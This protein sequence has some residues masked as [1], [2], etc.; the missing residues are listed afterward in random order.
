MLNEIGEYEQ[1]TLSPQQIDDSRN[2]RLKYM[3][4]IKR[5]FSGLERALTT[6]ARHFIFDTPVGSDE[7]ELREILKAWCGFASKAK[8]TLPEHFKGWLDKY[9]CRAF[10]NPNVN[11][12]LEEISWSEETKFFSELKGIIEKISADGNFDRREVLKALEAFKA[13]HLNEFKK[14]GNEPPQIL[15][16]VNA[17]AELKNKNK[18]FSKSVFGSLTSEGK[19]PFRAITYDRIIANALL[20]GKLRRFYL[21]CD[22]ELF[23][24]KKI[25]KGAKRLSANNKDMILKMTAEYLL[26]RRN[27][28]QLFT[29]TNDLNMVNWLAV[30]KKPENFD[31][32]KY[33]LAVS[34][35]NIFDVQKVN[36][37]GINATKFKLH[38]DWTKHFRLVEDTGDNL[39]EK[40]GRIF[41]SDAGSS[42]KLKECVRYDEFF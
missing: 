32:E 41:F 22:E 42:E 15:A 30:D 2:L 10:L 18:V 12:C 3:T 7:N 34:G 35:E 28:P 19:I 9:I 26:K 4:L 6:L 17:L 14:Y 25:L 11:S 20:A 8:T 40:L 38:P 16:T 29:E 33:R 21:V 24:T 5:N 36:L 13:T 27:S 1:Y 31:R 23:E 39:E 37:D